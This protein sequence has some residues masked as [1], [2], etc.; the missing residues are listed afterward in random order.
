M[1][2]YE[3]F[4]KDFARRGPPTNWRARHHGQPSDAFVALCR[5]AEGAGMGIG[6]A[7]SRTVVGDEG[8]ERRTFTAIEVSKPLADKPGRKV[9][10]ATGVL[11]E[12][13]LET[14]AMR[15]RVALEKRLVA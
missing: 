10:F 7:V 2:A 1:K 3:E 5:R 4:W 15:A 11:P 12:E 6:L 14:A 9:I 13:T 8:Q